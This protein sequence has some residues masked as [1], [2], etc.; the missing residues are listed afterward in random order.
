[1]RHRRLL[2]ERLE[3]IEK[4]LRDLQAARS[5]CANGLMKP[6]P[7]P[8]TATH[9]DEAGP[10]ITPAKGVTTSA[11]EAQLTGQAPFGCV[12]ESRRLKTS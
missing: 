6:A 9:L 4:A 12:L 7:V 1:M 2:Q 8:E 5:I 11:E 10:P 3:L